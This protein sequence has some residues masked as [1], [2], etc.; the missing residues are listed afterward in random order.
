[1]PLPKVGLPE[2]FESRVQDEIAQLGFDTSAPKALA[3]AVIRLS[4]HYLTATTGPHSVS[5]A[6][7]MA[8]PWAQ[9]AYLAYY[10]PLNFARALSV[11]QEGMRRGFFTDLEHVVDFGS[12][13]GAAVFAML[14]SG[15]RFPAGGLAIDASA[16]SL[17]LQARLGA[18]EAG[19][20]FKRLAVADGAPTQSVAGRA[21][22]ACF[23]YS[24]TEVGELPDWA[25]EC[26]ALFIIE[27]ST[28]RDGRRLQTRRAHLLENGFHPWAPC[29]HEQ[30]CP[31]LARSDRDW[32]HARALFAAPPW[33]QRLEAKLPM[34]NRS[35]THS[36]L[37]MRKTDA[38]QELRGATRAVGDPREEKGKTRI[39]ACRGPDR[40]FLAWF[41]QRMTAVERPDVERGALFRVPLDLPVKGQDQSREIRAS[42]RTQIEFI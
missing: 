13:S 41:P 20:D 8:K 39:A 22:L 14:E 34:K 1:M 7:L 9:A 17:D 2:R 32:C 10:F 27:P 31:L 37:L 3:Q 28:Q 23:S 25:L 29:T 33:W 30:A 4:D 6:E 15:A 24:L 19:Y 36:Y 35:I 21:T 18:G 16:E 42:S 5:F 26:E 40:E 38:P 12:G 11:A